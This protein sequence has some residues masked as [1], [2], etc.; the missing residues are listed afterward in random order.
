MPQS[1][2]VVS[3]EF[4]TELADGTFRS[5]EVT[6]GHN[7][8]PDAGVDGDGT[9]G[10][11]TVDFGLIAPLSLGDTVF[12]DENAN[13]TYEPGTDTLLDGVTVPGS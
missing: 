10:N 8:E 13:G 3:A 11:Q 9:N 1:L 4:A 5:G 6:L 7:E 12:V 2:N